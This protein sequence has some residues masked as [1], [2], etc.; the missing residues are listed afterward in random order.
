MEDLMLFKMIQ[1]SF[2]HPASDLSDF[3]FPDVKIG[4][5]KQNIYAI[6]LSNPESHFITDERYK[7][8]NMENSG[9]TFGIYLSPSSLFTKFV[10]IWNDNFL[11]HYPYSTAKSL[12]DFCARSAL[13]TILRNI[14][15]HGPNGQALTWMWIVK[16]GNV[17][18][19]DIMVYVAFY[20]V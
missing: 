14:S 20:I 4:P 6:W 13:I 12:N 19:T 9:K 17:R 2:Q 16:A 3:L 8:F 11:V 7:P 15:A 10:Y 18:I 5:V 1:L